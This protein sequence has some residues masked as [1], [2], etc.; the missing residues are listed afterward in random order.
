[1][2][3]RRS[4]TSAQGRGLGHSFAFE[5]MERGEDGATFVK[6]RP[7]YP[8]GDNPRGREI[9]FQAKDLEE[10]YGTYKPVFRGYRGKAPLEGQ[11][12]GMP[13]RIGSLDTI[14]DIRPDLPSRSVDTTALDAA[15]EQE[16]A[17]LESTDFFALFPEV[18]LSSPPPGTNFSPGQ[19]VIVKAEAT[20]IQNLT[21]AT[22]IVGGRAVDRKVLDR[23]D[24][25][26]GNVTR[27]FIFQYIIPDDQAL[28]S[29]DITV[30]VFNF[31]SALQGMVADDALNKPPQADSIKTA[32]GSVD[33]LRKHQ[34]TSSLQY[35]QRLEE[36]GLLRTP[37]GVS[38]ISINIV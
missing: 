22:L 5:N 12:F 26:V 3:E 6:R 15:K 31:A 8:I 19:T 38:S 1:M 9:D 35:S 7:T 18:T 11:D 37:Q 21:S 28:G 13:V 29:L 14:A 20:N 32:T 16:R 33:G 23:R 2:V 10:A 4:G 17:Q 27:I 24:Q 34:A 30:Q 25:A 36:T